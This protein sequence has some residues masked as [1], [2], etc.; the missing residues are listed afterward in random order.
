MTE[1]Q[2]FIKKINPCDTLSAE[3][4]GLY[5]TADTLPNALEDTLI[6]DN[7]LKTLGFLLT[8]SGHGNWE[9]GP[10]IVEL[11]LVKGNCKCKVF[12]KY[13]YKDKLSDGKY[14][15][16]LTEKLVCNSDKNAVY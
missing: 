14:N 15:L 7:Y 3:F 1:P 13:Y 11:A 16:Q 12:K 2:A 5:T 8:S 10:R 9:A 4:E 6:V